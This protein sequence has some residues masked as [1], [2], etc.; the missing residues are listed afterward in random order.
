MID[1]AWPSKLGAVQ[2]F[3]K[4]RLVNSMQHAKIAEGVPFELSSRGE[5]QILDLRKARLSFHDFARA[6]WPQAHTRPVIE[7]FALVILQL[8]ESRFPGTRVGQYR[9]FVVDRSRHCK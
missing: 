5:M 6:Y 7:T 4:C 9:K 1:R 2:E 3:L 8:P